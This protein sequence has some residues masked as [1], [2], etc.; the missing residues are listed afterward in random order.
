MATSHAIDVNGAQA[1]LG[2]FVV[3]AQAVQQVVAGRQALGERAL[4]GQRTADC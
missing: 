3:L 4:S 2:L 1:E